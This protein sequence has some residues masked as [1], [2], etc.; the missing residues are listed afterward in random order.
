[1][2]VSVSLSGIADINGMNRLHYAQHTSINCESAEVIV[3]QVNW[4]GL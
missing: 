4:H 3:D 2:L 1:M